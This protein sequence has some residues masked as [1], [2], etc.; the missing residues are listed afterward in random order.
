MRPPISAR[1]EGGSFKVALGVR[2]SCD[3]SI[4][5][6]MRKISLSGSK[7][8]SHEELESMSE[9]GDGNQQHEDPNQEHDDDDDEDKSKMPP[10]KSSIESILKAAAIQNQQQHHQGGHHLG[11]LNVS[12]DSKPRSRSLIWRPHRKP[13]KS[14]S[15]VDQTECR[16]S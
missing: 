11:R 9:L 16:V 1:A 15:G 4:V 12:H 8:S 13:S 3:A 10:Q 7:K 6:S 5:T 14:S 2:K